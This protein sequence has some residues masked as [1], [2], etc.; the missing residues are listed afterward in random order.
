MR[1]LWHTR[2]HLPMTFLEEGR[3]FF[4]RV[5]QFLARIGK[6]ERCVPPHRGNHGVV[7]GPRPCARL[8]GCLGMYK[9]SQ[10]GSWLRRA[11]GLA[12]ESSRSGCGRCADAKGG[13]R[14][15]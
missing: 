3:V 4:H 14:A 1:R 7:R 13:Q 8:L 5:V 9:L 15:G 2:S 6:A 11:Q 10:D 12:R